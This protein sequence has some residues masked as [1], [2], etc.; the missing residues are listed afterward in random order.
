MSSSSG[1]SSEADDEEADGGS[2]GEPPGAPQEGTALGNGNPRTEDDK[3]DSPPPSYPAQ[4]VWLRRFELP[5]APG[6]L[7]SACVSPALGSSGR[8][9]GPCRVAPKAH[10]GESRG[11]FAR[12][13]QDW[14][15]RLSLSLSPEFC[16]HRLGFAVPQSVWAFRCRR[17]FIFIEAEG[18]VVC[19]FE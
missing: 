5:V 1:S 3:A 12:A 15:P 13:P 4:Q 18:G 9:V 17:E 16:L 11:A 19:L 14:G 8:R 7:L 2:S 10:P 6:P